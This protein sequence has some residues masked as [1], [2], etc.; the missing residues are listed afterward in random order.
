MRWPNAVPFKHKWKDGAEHISGATAAWTP[1]QGRGSVVV[2]G[3]VLP[4]YGPLSYHELCFLLSHIPIYIC[5]LRLGGECRRHR[6]GSRSRKVICITRAGTCSGSPDHLLGDRKHQLPAGHAVL[7]EACVRIQTCKK[8][9]C[10]SSVNE[11][12]R[13][14]PPPC[15]SLSFTST[16]HI[17]NW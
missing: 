14:F 1:D 3:L 10:T 2:L 17:H 16:P 12:R 13:T 7:S 6:W 4:R 15:C 5:S 8:R 9:S 11:A